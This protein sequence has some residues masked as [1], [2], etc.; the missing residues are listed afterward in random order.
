MGVF[1]AGDGTCLEDWRVVVIVKKFRIQNV[2]F[3]I[4]NDVGVSRKGA[5]AKRG[6]QQVCYLAC[7]F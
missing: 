4:Q 1:D 3:R 2:E 7:V 5:K 6:V